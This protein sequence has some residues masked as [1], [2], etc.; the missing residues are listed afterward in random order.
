MASADQISCRNL[1]RQ[2][3]ASAPT[4]RGGRGTARRVVVPHGWL[5]RAAAIARASGAQRSVCA[6]GCEEMSGNRGKDYPQSVQQ[7][8][9]IPQSRLR[10]DSSLYTREPLGTGVRAAEVVD[11]YGKPNHPPQASRRAAKR[12]RPRGRGMGGN[13]RKNHPKRGPPPRL[14]RQRLAKR[15]ARKEQLV[16]S[17]L[18]PMT[19][20]CS[21][22]HMV[23]KFEQGPARAHVE[24]ALTEQNGLGPRPAA[25]QGAPRP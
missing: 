22:A 6:S 14:P 9:T 20:L 23:W 13:R 17:G 19:E 7:R 18:C 1:G 8:W 10:R 5:R 2:S 3:W 12:P 25:R 16:K 4:P 11:L 24:A 21:T 15:K